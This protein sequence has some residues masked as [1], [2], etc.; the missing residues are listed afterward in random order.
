[1]LDATGAPHAPLSL[2]EAGPIGDQPAAPV[3][4]ERL[5]RLEQ[6]L[7]RLPQR[8]RRLVVRRFGLATDAP[9]SAATLAAELELSP[10]RTQT[11]AREALDALRRD[12]E[13]DEN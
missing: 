9:V 6:M 11:I 10:R 2:D 13:A 7:A 5:E 8:Q 4:D 12:L 1:V 3:A